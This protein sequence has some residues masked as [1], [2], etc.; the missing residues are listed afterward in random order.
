MCFISGK[1]YKESLNSS[2][3]CV[4]LRLQLGHVLQYAPSFLRLCALTFEFLDIPVWD[5]SAANLF[6]VRATNPNYPSK[7]LFCAIA[8]TPRNC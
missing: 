1:R 7:D 6:A 8:E 5:K 2:N 3:L 4:A